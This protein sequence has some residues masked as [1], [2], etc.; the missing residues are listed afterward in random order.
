MALTE[1]I[2]SENTFEY[3]TSVAKQARNQPVK[4]AAIE[5]L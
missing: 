4:K 2:F 5:R 1:S 3:I